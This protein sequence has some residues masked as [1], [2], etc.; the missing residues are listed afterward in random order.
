MEMMKKRDFFEQLNIVKSC[1][2][3]NLS[4]WQ[5]P[6]FLFLVMGIIIIGVILCTYYFGTHYIPQIEVV[7]LIVFLTVVILFTIAFLICHSF[8]KIA[9][10]N[11]A[12]AHFAW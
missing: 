4:L 3:Y 12:F 10:A 11:K 6:Q 8:E 7:L 2:K 9:E 5:C 1:R